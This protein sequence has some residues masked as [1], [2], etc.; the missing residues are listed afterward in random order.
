MCQDRAQCC[1]VISAGLRALPAASW[2]PLSLMACSWAEDAGEVPLP[3]RLRG[4]CQLYVGSL[5]A[6]EDAAFHAEVGVSDVLTAAGRLKPDFPESCQPAHLCLNLADHPTANLLAELSASIAFCDTARSRPVAESPQ[7]LL[8][9][10]ASG[11]SRSVGV[12]IAYLMVRGGLSYSEGLAA[13]KTN[14][15]QACPNIGFQRQL[16]LLEECGCDVD[17]AQQRWSDESGREVM[18]AARAERDAA[19]AIHERLDLLE[20]EVAKARSCASAAG[21]C[22]D[23]VN[24]QFIGRL[25]HLQTQIDN[26]MGSS[27]DRAALTI[28]KAAS[29]KCVRLLDGFQV[30]DSPC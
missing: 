10:C 13:V 22:L 1:A 2:A 30:V 21:N 16:Q 4:T 11:V 8:V 25:D 6:A 9:H 29:R 24:Q 18:D 5:C 20:E 14:R 12:C 15:E 19:N 17:A 26:C 23:A 27:H 28:L 3:E 7:A